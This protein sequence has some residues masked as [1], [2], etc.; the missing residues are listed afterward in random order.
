MESSKMLFI[1][2]FTNSWSS[3]QNIEREST[4]KCK[5]RINK[6]RSVVKCENFKMFHILRGSIIG[7][8]ERTKRSDFVR[9]RGS[10]L[11]NS[12]KRTKRDG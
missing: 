8:R 11:M 6:D 3:I 2:N 9:L 5:A 12:L 7:G 10:T 1:N 4:P